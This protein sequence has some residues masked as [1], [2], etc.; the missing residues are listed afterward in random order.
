MPIEMPHEVALFLNFCGVPYPDINEDDVR[1]LGEHVREFAGNVQ[2]THQSA[3]RAVKDMGS[4]YSGYSYE[5]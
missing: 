1:R 4:V 3:T 2:Q 5:Q